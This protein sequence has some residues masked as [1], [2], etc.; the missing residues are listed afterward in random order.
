LPTTLLR[1]GGVAGRFDEANALQVNVTGGATS[2]SED[3]ELNGANVCAVKTGSNDE[4]VQYR[5]ATLMSGTT[6]RLTGLLR[7]Q[8]GTAA[9]MGNPT[10]GSSEV[11]SSE[12]VL[13]RR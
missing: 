2:V 1:R 5:T 9:V 7:G 10:A 8:G 13:I 11:R 4:V 3:A 12:R 6:Y